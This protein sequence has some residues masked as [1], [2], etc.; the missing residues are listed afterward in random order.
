MTIAYATFRAS[1][2]TLQASGLKF[3]LL[4]LGRNAGGL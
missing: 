3:I 4:E 1:S 2:T